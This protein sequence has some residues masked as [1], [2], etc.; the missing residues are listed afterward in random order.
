MH[1][2]QPLEVSASANCKRDASAT[3]PIDHGLPANF[4]PSVVASSGDAPSV[5][6]V[7]AHA[8]RIAGM[9]GGT[10]VAPVD[11][12]LAV[13]EMSFADFRAI[14]GWPD[15][16]HINPE[17]CIWVATVHASM[18]VK[19]PPGQSPRAADVYSVAID[20]ASGTMIGVLT[21]SDLIR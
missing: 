20:A 1:R 13:R 2:T 6:Q 4:P 9:F 16:Q 11:A 8:R 3:P 19:V 7:R 10:S 17:R 18:A 21:G 5:G 14:S 12:P 15:N